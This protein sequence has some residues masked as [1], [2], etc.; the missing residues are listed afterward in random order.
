MYRPNEE[1]GVPASP[2]QRTVAIQLAEAGKKLHS[3]EKGMTAGAMWKSEV[4]PQGCSMEM[5]V[6]GFTEHAI[7]Q[8]E[9]RQ[10]GSRI[11]ENPGADQTMAKIW[12]TAKPVCYIC[13]ERTLLD[14][15]V[16]NLLPSG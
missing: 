1:Q 7:A 10:T 8:K 11:E 12:W 4:D 14:L 15:F 2:A 16:V 3:G 6:K 13:Q 5:S 9:M